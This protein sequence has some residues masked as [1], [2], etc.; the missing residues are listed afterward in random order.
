MR[1]AEILLANGAN[2]NLK[3]KEGDSSILYACRL[4]NTP[5]ADLLL[6]H[7]ANVY[8]KHINSGMSPILYASN[9]RTTPASCCC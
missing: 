1:I 4:D 5:L 7:G 3:T 2:V 9:S 8:E 6:K